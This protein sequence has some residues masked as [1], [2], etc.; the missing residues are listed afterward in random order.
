VVV[1]QFEELFTLNPPSVQ[2]RFAVLLGRLASEADVHVLISLRDDFL[3]RC[4]GHEAL[5]PIFE[6][7]TPLKAPEG[8]TLRRALVEPAARQGVAFEDE[9]L[10]EKM[11]E[12]VSGERG[13]LPLLAF[14]ISRLWEERDREKKQLTHAAYE[15]IGGVAG[16]LAR[17]A[18]ATLDRIGTERTPLVR[19]LFRNLVTAQETRAAREGEDLLSVFPESGRAEATAVLN[20]LVNARLLTSCERPGADDERKPHVEIVHESLLTHWPRLVRWQIQ[21]ADGALLRDQLRQAAQLWSDRGRV[22]DLLWTGAAYRDFALWRERYGGGLSATEHAFADAA[23][24]LA[25]PRRRQRRLAAAILLATTAAVAITTSALWRES[26]RSRHKAEA[27]ARQRGAAELLALGRLQLEKYPGAALAHAIASLE[28][29]DNEPARRFAVEALWKA[30]PVHVITDAVIPVSVRWSPDGRWLALGGTAGLALLDRDTGERLE[31]ASSVAE[32]PVGFSADGARG[33]TETVGGVSALDRRMRTF[34]FDASGEAVVRSARVEERSIDGGPVRVLGRWRTH[35]LTDH[36]VDSAGERLFSVQ[37][38]RLFEQRLDALEVPPRLL[39]R[40]DGEVSVWARQWTRR[41]VTADAGGEVRV[42]NATIG[43]LERTLRSPGSALKVALD[44]QGRFLATGPDGALPPNTLFLFDLEASRAAAPTGLVQDHAHWLNTM[45]ID[46]S[47]HWLAAGQ[48]G[49]VLLWNL[50]GRRSTVLRGQRG[51]MIAVAFAP[52]GGLVST[53]DEGV[54]RLWSVGAA[55][56]EPV[57]VLWSE[58][59]AYVGARVDVDRRGRFAVDARRAMARLVVI[60]LDGSPAHVFALRQDR[61]SPRMNAAVSIEP[62]G[63]RLAIAY[64]EDGNPGAGSI[65]IVDAATGSEQTLR[66]PTTT[67]ACMDTVA[68]Y[69]AWDIPVWLP[70][71]PLAS[72]GA[73]GVRVWDVA[74]GTSRQVRPC[75]YSDPASLTPTPDSRAVLVLDHRLPGNGDSILSIVDLATGASRDIT[76]HGTR[77]HAIALDPRG[78]MLVT[79][80]GDGLIRV[81]PLTGEAPHLLYGHTRAVTGVAVSPD[82]KWIASGSDD[83]TIRLWP[84]PQGPPL[85]TLPH[86]ELLAKLRS[87]TNLRVVPD[88]SAATG[89]K[90]EPGPFPV[91]KSADMVSPGKDA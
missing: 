67:G 82:G 40:H 3:I 86:D 8:E 42:W 28:R 11:L 87:L 27:E 22:A 71:G 75:S 43:R 69:G 5:S 7:L 30:P 19:E 13:A 79:G 85:H 9:A 31:L 35:G 37:A 12:A 15:R 17:H 77:I 80:G 76:S 50:I 60:P 47:G 84:M 48:A 6:E 70:D 64:A 18:E 90:V 59:D 32:G 88:A 23:T 21:D 51:V 29:A 38:G 10:V 24:K 55:A 91:G 73:T 33:V 66:A 26:E 16:A 1:D 74:A 58:K 62:S 68:Q 34:D 53:S 20:E 61:R 36:D 4:H 65:R 44:P 81:G 39:G 41:L 2:G 49:S 14:A 83:E 57:R 25:T 63:Q 56:D 89:Y 45:A 54:V 52:D 78:T 46:P 72:V